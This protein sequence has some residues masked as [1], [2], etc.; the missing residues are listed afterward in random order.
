MATS[1]RE[2]FTGSKSDPVN[3]ETG[4]RK[5]NRDAN[6]ALRA[7]REARQA[8]SFPNWVCITSGACS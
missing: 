1:R 6:S 2:E 7:A 5:D 8:I 4:S 3:E